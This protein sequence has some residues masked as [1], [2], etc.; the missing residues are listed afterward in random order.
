MLLLFESASGYGLF[1]VNNGSDLTEVDDVQRLLGDCDSSAASKYFALEK[2]QPIRDTAEAL[3]CA[4]ALVESKISKPL[5][6]LLKKVADTEELAVSDAKLGSLIK[7]KYNI[8]CVYSSVVLEMM[9]VV[10]QHLTELAS[11]SV[12]TDEASGMALGLAHSLSRYKL[13]FSPDKVDTMIV[14]AISLLDDLDKELNNMMMRMREWYGWH[15][16]E[17]TKIISDNLAYAKV[18]R[19]MGLRK[20]AKTTDFEKVLTEEIEASLKESAELSMGCEISEQDLLTVFHLADRVIELSEYRSKLYEYLKNRMEAIAPNLTMLVG[21]LVGARLIAHAGNLVNL[22]KHPA[23]T[24]Q[25]LG[26]EKA[27]FRAL[28]TKKDTPKYGL[29]YHASLVGQSSAKNKGRMSRMLAAKAALALRYDAFGDADESTVELGINNR[30]KL[31]RR[32]K[33]LETG[34]VEK[35]PFKKEKKKEAKGAFTVKSETMEY[36]E[37][38]DSTLKRKK[39]EVKEE[40]PEEETAEVEEPPKKKKKK[41]K[42]KEKKEAKEESA[43]EV[44]AEVVSAEPAEPAS[45]EKKKKKKK[46]KKADD[47][48][49]LNVTAQIEEA[50][51]QVEEMAVSEEAATESP[52]KKKKKKKSK[53]A[54]EVEVE[55]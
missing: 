36:D 17:M 9:R 42:K 18:V 8:Q 27:L 12:T 55:E 31:E 23:S 13:K 29:I 26:A 28:K 3:Q 52:K 34:K 15:F 11:N 5:K 33:V 25:V 45:P 54:V 7:E 35:S 30:A 19:L 22:A 43:E 39:E 53:A 1:R 14:Q 2:F 10:R 49:E 40:A 44:T 6:K 50:A 46:S 51:E 32:L 48:D 20:N 37:A 38:A 41:D 47:E 16:P 24:I 21:E 4:T